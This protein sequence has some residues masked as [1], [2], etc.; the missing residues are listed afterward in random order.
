MSEANKRIVR[1]FFAAMDNK[2]F[3][4]MRDL[5]HPDHLFHLPMAKEPLDK[6]THMDMN[7]KLQ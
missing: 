2:R 5:L 3:D 1:D 6:E 7:M 4:E